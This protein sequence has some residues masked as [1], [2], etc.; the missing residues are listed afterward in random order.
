MCGLCSVKFLIFWKLKFSVS[1]QR[2]EDWYWWLGY[3]FFFF[4]YL[5][6]FFSCV[7]S[8]LFDLLPFL[9]SDFIS[10]LHYFEI[11]IS[12]FFLSLFHYDFVVDVPLLFLVHFLWVCIIFKLKLHILLWL[13]LNSFWFLFLS[14]KFGVTE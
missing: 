13:I 9:N 4:F 3:S 8:E 10:I 11:W 2:T 1:Q 7:W 6:F 5:N 14:S 12:N